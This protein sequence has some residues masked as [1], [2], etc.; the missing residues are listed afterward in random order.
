M[1]GKYAAYQIWRRE[2]GNYY[3]KVYGWG[4]TQVEAVAQ[5]VTK[6]QGRGLSVSDLRTASG[7]E[8]EGLGLPIEEAEPITGKQAITVRIDRRIIAMAK[9]QAQRERRS[10]T[11]LV[12]LALAEYVGRRSE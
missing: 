2:N 10:F 3:V 12:E 4:E 8:L 6:W 1:A 7:D 11:S 5:A 9:E